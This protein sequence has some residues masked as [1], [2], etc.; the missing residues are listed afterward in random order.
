MSQTKEGIIKAKKTMLKKYGKTKDGK[1]KFHVQ[2]GKAG[3]LAPHKTPRGFASKV[4]DKKG[5]TG[6]QR[7]VIYGKIGGTKSRRG[8][9]VDKS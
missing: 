5:L 3:G 4:V 8:K 6:G 9:A 7:A 2:A 1:S